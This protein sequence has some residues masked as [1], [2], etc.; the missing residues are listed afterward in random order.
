M[1]EQFPA[2]VN[3]W[4]ELRK[5]L[6]T[7]LEISKPRTAASGYNAFRKLKVVHLKVTFSNMAPEGPDWPR[8]VF[9]GVGIGIVPLDKSFDKKPHWASIDAHMK[10]YGHR[11]KYY[12][13]GSEGNNK[14]FEE[15]TEEERADGFFLFPGDSWTYELYV[16]VKDIPNYDFYVE[17]SVSR[18]HLFHY[19]EKLTITYMKQF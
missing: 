10:Q 14:F 19:Q 5:Y 3:L 2:A 12:I 15:L 4:Q 11:K 1:S 8:I 6:K 13:T 17:A 16:P 7:E 9:T 18:R